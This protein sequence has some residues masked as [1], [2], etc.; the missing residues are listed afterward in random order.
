MALIAGGSGTQDADP[1]NVDDVVR[2]AMDSIIRVRTRRDPYDNRIHAWQRVWKP[3]VVAPEQ[4]R[5]KIQL[6]G[7]ICGSSCMPPFGLGSRLPCR[8]SLHTG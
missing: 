2:P 3:I 6:L 4:I 8:K 5:Q 7:T 1:L